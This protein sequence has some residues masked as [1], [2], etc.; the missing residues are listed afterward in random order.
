MI[1][2]SAFLI[3]WDLVRF[4]AT[5]A[6]AHM[7]VTT[8]P[9]AATSTTVDGKLVRVLNAPDGNVDGLVLANGAIARFPLRRCPFNLWKGATLRIRGEVVQGLPG[10]YLMNASILRSEVPSGGN[11]SWPPAPACPR[12]LAKPDRADGNR[13]TPAG[14]RQLAVTPA[15]A[16]AQVGKS[17]QAHHLPAVQSARPRR[18]QQGDRLDAAT[19]WLQRLTSG[20]S[21]RSTRSEWRPERRDGG[22]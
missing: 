16:W 6:V 20:T 14:A 17:S 7:P 15:G 3:V 21:V 8:Q 18:A 10:P 1:Y 9:T 4:D 22:F 19:S 12:G 13:G 2:A 5:E 11:G